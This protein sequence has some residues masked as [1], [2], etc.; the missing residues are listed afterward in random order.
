MSG[1][2]DDMLYEVCHYCF[3]QG[4][5]KNEGYAEC[6]YCDGTGFEIYML[7]DEDEMEDEADGFDR[8][9]EQ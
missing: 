3:G 9:D 4:Y 7:D 8:S 5:L 2:S 1:Q 6:P